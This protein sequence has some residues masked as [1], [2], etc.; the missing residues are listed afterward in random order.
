[1]AGRTGLSGLW[2]LSVTLRSGG[3][4]F[5]LSDEFAVGISTSGQCCMACCSCF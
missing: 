3:W 1:M 2:V 5:Y 4:E